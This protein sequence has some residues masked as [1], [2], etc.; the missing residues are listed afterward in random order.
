MYTC[1]DCGKNFK[2]ISKLQE[3]TNRQT[4]CRPATHHCGR[5]NK[6]LASYRSLC[7][8][9]QRCREEFSVGR[10]AYNK[11]REKAVPRKRSLGY[12]IPTIDGNKFS[13][14][15]ISDDD[16]DEIPTFD[17]DQFCGNKLLTQQTLN[18][19][20]KLLKIPKE[21]W[22]QVAKEELQVNKS[23]LKE[24]AKR[25][26][27]VEEIESCPRDSSLISEEELRLPEQAKNLLDDKTNPKEFSVGTLRF[28]D[29]DP[30]ENLEVKNL[31]NIFKVLHRQLLNDRKQENT[32]KLIAIL[33]TLLRREL[34]DH[35]GYKKAL[36][37]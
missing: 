18:R 5:C 33:D 3:H 7:N 2:I 35:D 30:F 16:D 11:I 8:H 22:D 34:I 37:K 17:G 28:D 6:G 25:S 36:N 9:K 31:R 20:M 15:R 24:E 23:K 19:M 4:P 27:F 26:V 21:K 29:N 10:V 1:N 14:K 13:R 12:E 32:T